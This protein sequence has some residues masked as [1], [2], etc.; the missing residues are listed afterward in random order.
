MIIWR[1]AILPV[2][3][4]IFAGWFLT[5]GFWD[6]VR[7]SMLVALS[8]IAAAVLVRLAR[9]LP[10]TA[11]EEIEVE[12]AR[13][14]VHAV[15]QVMRSLQ[16]LIR[17]ALASMVWLVFLKPTAAYVVSFEPLKQH[18]TGIEIFLS[19]LT[20]LV[21]S[22]VFVRILDVLRGDYD[23]VNLQGDFMVRTVERRKAARFEQ[24]HPASATEAF[25]AP[26]GYGKPIQ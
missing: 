6:D 15:K 9:G 22:Y 2:A 20:G 25:R 1:T 13:S 8:V 7:Q 23:V 17:I 14:V 12:E 5:I 10:F 16:H 18:S 11:T 21:L 4:A 19:G 3:G 24:D 26:E